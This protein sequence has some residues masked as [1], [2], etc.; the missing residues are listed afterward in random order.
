M[1][2]T[3]QKGEVYVRVE[4]VVSLLHKRAHECYD[5]ADKQDKKTSTGRIAALMATSAAKIVRISA[6]DIAKLQ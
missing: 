4:D 2:I 6:D 5:E 1:R 3:I